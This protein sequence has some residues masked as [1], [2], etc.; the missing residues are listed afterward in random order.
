MYPHLNEILAF[1]IWLDDLPI[2]VDSR[3]SDGDMLTAG[4][5][6]GGAKFKPCI[7]RVGGVQAGGRP[8]PGRSG[9][10]HGAEFDMA[11]PRLRAFSCGL[12]RPDPNASHRVLPR[13]PFWVQYCMLGSCAQP[14]LTSNPMMKR[15]Y[16]VSISN[17]IDYPDW[18]CKGSP[19]RFELLF[20]VTH[21]DSVQP[22]CGRGIAG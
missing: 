11:P 5:A 17:S 19:Q 12:L 7:R 1:H 21:I 15:D 9:C 8:A 4:A 20:V 6:V 13:M 14:A 2:V 18:N 3:S 10:T 16:P 22:G